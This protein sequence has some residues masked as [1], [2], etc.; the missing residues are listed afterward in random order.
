MDVHCK[1]MEPKP[2]LSG[3]SFM[4]PGSVVIFSKE[5]QR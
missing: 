2:K 4:E 3:L 1:E 5:E